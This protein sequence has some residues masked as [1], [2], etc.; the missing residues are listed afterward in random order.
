V[1]LG[2][3]TETER[4][5]EWVGLWCHTNTYTTHSRPATARTHVVDHARILQGGKAYMAQ[6]VV[7]G[8]SQSSSKTPSRFAA[9]SFVLVLEGFCAPG[10]SRSSVWNGIIMW[11]CRYLPCLLY[12]GNDN[13][14]GRGRRNDGT[15]AENK[16]IRL[17][18]AFPSFLWVWDSVSFALA[19]LA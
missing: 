10:C 17:I 1:A 15:G 5:S 4:G 13:E 19:D 9:R 12:Q 2:I 11:W 6:H 14:E 3:Y 18:C 16:Y 7:S 8:R